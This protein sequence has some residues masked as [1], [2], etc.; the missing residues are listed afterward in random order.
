MLIYVLYDVL[1]QDA[2]RIFLFKNDEMAMRFLKNAIEIPNSPFLLNLK[3][4][5]LRCVGSLDV[6]SCS[7]SGAPSNDSLY[8]VVEAFNSYKSEFIAKQKKEINNNVK[9]FK[10]GK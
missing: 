9:E 6:D 2:S 5:E 4:M 8:Y 1:A 7:V 10:N 3:D